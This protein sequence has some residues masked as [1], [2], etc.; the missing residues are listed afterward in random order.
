[1][2][3]P[4]EFYAMFRRFRGLE[5]RSVIKKALELGRQGTGDPAYAAI[6]A[7]ALAALTKL[8]G[9]SAINEQRVSGLYQVP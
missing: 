4:D 6:G 9:E 1:M 3:T 7:N 8:R 2:R 5:L